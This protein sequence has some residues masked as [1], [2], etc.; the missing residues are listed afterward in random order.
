MINVVEHRSMEQK[1]VKR[2]NV[3]VQLVISQLIPIDV[4]KILVG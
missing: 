3:N 4:F 2:I 1:S